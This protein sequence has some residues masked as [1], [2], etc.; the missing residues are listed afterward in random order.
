M[1]KKS[2]S[3]AAYCSV[4]RSSGVGDSYSGEQPNPNLHT[5]VEH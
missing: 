5:F 4:D 3:Q 1:V 2:S